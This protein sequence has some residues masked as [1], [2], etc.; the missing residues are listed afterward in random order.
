MII[1]EIPPSR[2]HGFTVSELCLTEPLN[3]AVIF[4]VTA[5]PTAVVV[6][7]KLGD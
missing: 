5:V 1:F 4:T 7:V 6:I 2:H 3:V